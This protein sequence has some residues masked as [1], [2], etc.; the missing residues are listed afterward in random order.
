MRKA[1]GTLHYYINGQD[2]GVSDTRTPTP[3]WGVVD[4]YGMAVKVTILDPNDP[5]YADYIDSGS[6]RVNSVMRALRNT[7]HNEEGV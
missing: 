5:N 3:V 2:Q 4:L 6:R 7:M 1:S